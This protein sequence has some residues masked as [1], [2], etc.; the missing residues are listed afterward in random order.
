MTLADTEKQSA[1]PQA[2]AEQPA[3][4]AGEEHENP[5]A[6]SP[7]EPDPSVEAPELVSVQENFEGVTAKKGQKGEKEAS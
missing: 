5:S 3:T 2:Q 7:I 1:D 6:L 4:S